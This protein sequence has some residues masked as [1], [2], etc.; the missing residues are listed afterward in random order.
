MPE[1]KEISDLPLGLIP[2]TEYHQTA[3]RLARGDLLI[4]Y[5]DSI[6]EAEMKL[7]INWVWRVCCRWRAVCPSTPRLR[8]GKHSWRR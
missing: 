2:G 1:A 4:L 5:T 7:A 8:Q 3:V 6:N